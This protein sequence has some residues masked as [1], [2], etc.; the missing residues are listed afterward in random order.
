M[1]YAPAASY[2]DFDWL[3]YDSGRFFY[4]PP[5]AKIR[6]LYIPL[7]QEFSAFC[8]ELSPFRAQDGSLCYNQNTGFD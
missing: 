8:V 6:R 5:S 2:E 4:P 7:I 3:E 1:G